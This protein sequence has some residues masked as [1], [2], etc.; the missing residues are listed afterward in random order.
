M[1]ENEILQRNEFLQR[2]NQLTEEEK[3]YV[4]AMVE[5]RLV[6]PKYYEEANDEH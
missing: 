5:E 4:I 2:F 1:S 6:D 3:R